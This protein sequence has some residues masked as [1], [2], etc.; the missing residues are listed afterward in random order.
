MLVPQ[1]SENGFE[2]SPVH[3]DFTTRTVLKMR[4]QAPQILEEA[5]AL[6]ALIRLVVR[7]EVSTIVKEIQ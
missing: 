6:G 7:P 2:E 4:G 5:I 1:R 3:T